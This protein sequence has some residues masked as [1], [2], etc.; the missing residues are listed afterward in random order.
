[1]IFKIHEILIIKRRKFNEKKYINNKIKFIII[2]YTNTLIKMNL[3]DDHILD[4]LNKL[5]IT[6]RLN[7]SQILNLI[8]LVSI[9][10][11]LSDLRENLNWE[12]SNKKF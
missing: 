1:M 5:I 7:K 11:D 12:T 9:S 3:K 4:M 6:D 8:N 10:N 2:L